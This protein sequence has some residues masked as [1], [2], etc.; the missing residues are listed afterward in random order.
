V[1]TEKGVTLE[2]LIQE[3]EWYGTPAY[4]GQDCSECGEYHFCDGLCLR[5]KGKGGTFLCFSCSIATGRKVYR[6]H[7]HMETL[8]RALKKKA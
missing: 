3:C 7:D 6:Q 8:W 4:Y 2:E 1:V 5:F